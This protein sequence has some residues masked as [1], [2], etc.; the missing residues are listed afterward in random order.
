MSRFA[1]GTD[2]SRYEPDSLR[3]GRPRLKE[4]FR[5]KEPRGDEPVSRRIKKRKPRGDEPVSRRIERRRP[6]GDEP[7]SRRL[8]KFEKIQRRK[9]AKPS[10][11]EAGDGPRIRRRKLAAIRA[12]RRRKQRLASRTRA[13][14]EQDRRQARRRRREIARKRG[15]TSQ[16]I[17][18]R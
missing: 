18:P 16:D 5:K 8:E 1:P 17:Q 2:L 12:E 9:R 13:E 14:R 4:E 15:G 11:P 10:R 3:G 7:V 6:R